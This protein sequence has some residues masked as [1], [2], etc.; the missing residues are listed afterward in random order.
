[1]AEPPATIDEE[2]RARAARAEGPVL[3]RDRREAAARPERMPQA[4][5]PAA[6]ARATRATEAASKL[7]KPAITLSRRRSLRAVRSEAGNWA[8]GDMP[9]LNAIL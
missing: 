7:A 6:A 5:P 1:V 8:R 3:E 9:V 4:D 2:L